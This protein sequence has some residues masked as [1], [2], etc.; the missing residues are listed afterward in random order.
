M[1]NIGSQPLGDIFQKLLQIS[2]SG[3]IADATG[4]SLGVAIS[5]SNLIV[6][7][8]ISASGNLLI[9]GTSTVLGGQLVFGDSPADSVQFL[10]DVT[11]SFIPDLNDAFNL[12]SNAQRWNDLYLSGSISASGGPHDI[13]SD[14]LFSLTSPKIHITGPITASG[15]ISQ[16]LS[17]SGSF[18][19][20]FFGEKLV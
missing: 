14:T 20:A 1:S 13:Q 10:A 6:D 5:A 11:S 3:Y 8:N 12:G 17:R 16:S 15:D 19:H 4:S 9:I 2:S 18:G 7:G